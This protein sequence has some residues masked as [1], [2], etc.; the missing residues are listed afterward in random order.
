MVRRVTG[1]REITRLLL[2]FPIEVLHSERHREVVPQRVVDGAAGQELEHRTCRI[3]V[4]V[5]VEEV[6]AGLPRS[7]RRRG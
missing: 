5:V 7:T 6:G 4:P 2:R 3:E 1:D